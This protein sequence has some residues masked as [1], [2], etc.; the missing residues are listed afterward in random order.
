MDVYS[1]VKRR[2]NFSTLMM[3]VGSVFAGT[4]AAALRGNLEILP[5]S[6]CLLFVIFAQ[7]SANFSHSYIAASRY[8]EG[9]RQPRY[10][11]LPIP[12]TNKLAVRVLRES[13]FGCGIIACMFGF[14]IIALAT[15]PWW[16]LIVGLLIAGI[17][18]LLNLGKHPQFGRPMSLFFT[19]LLFG[20]VC[21]IATSLLQCQHEA[22]AAWGWFDLAPSLFLGPAMG[23]LACNIQLLY[24]YCIYRVEPNRTDVR[25]LTYQW[26]PGVV[27]ALF[28]LNGLLMLA[29]LIWKVFYL[30]LRAPLIAIAPAFIT[31]ALN[32][33]IGLR[34]RYAPVGELRHLGMLCK[35]NY[36]L[37]GVLTFIVWWWIGAPDD[38]LM[39]IF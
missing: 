27:R 37:M 29:L 23:F 21:V 4:A 15:T 34:M 17:N 22:V 9:L 2:A 26:G 35:I 20:P 18:W 10:A 24:G 19:W 14:A 25:G 36:L 32:T 16:V 8:Y 5:A 3:G 11:I 6:I 33:Y 13:A 39:V 28:I 38:S 7:L 31:F 1:Y 12:T 30:D